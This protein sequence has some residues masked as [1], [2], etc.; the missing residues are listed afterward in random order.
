MSAID[1]KWNSPQLIFDLPQFN[2]KALDARQIHPGALGAEYARMVILPDGKWLVVYTAF[3]NHGYRN[4]PDGGSILQFSISCDEGETWKVVSSLAHPSRDLDNGQ[5]L[6]LNNGEILLCCRS[7][8][9]QESYQLPVYISPDS[10]LTWNFLSIIDERNGA[11]GSLGKPDKGMYEPHLD[12]LQDGRISVMYAN[13][14]HVTEPSQ[15]S[16]IISQKISNDYGKTWGDEILVAWD[17]KAPQLR[18]GMPVWLQMKDGRYIVVFE[19]VVMT[20]G[21]VE[22]AAIYYKISEDGICWEPGIGIRIENQDGGP[23]I[24]EMADGTLVVTS[25]SGKISASRDTGSTWE[26][27]KSLPF[28][29]HLWPSI[30]GMENNQVVLLNSCSRSEGGH[31]IQI[32]VGEV[33]YNRV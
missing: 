4:Q 6:L 2:D 8:R 12:F 33:V 21:K 19:V 5:M 10:G 28:K 1:I 29:A 15:Y 3:E 32:C 14:K 13:E 22:S 11:P 7:V 25:V 16:Q 23:F 31:N 24:T 26:E 30:Y 27:I 17:E 18:P 20:E 9:W